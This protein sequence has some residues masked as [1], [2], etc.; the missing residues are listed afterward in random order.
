MT[1]NLAVIWNKKR[2]R[3]YTRR[4]FR[5]IR[6]KLYSKEDSEDVEVLFMGF[7]NEITE[8]EIEDVVDLEAKLIN[9]HEELEKYKRMYKKSKTHMI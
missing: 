4:T 3:P 8:E 2:I 6:K 5:K 9:S 1:E 7:E